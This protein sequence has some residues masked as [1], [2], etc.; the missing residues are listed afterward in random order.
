MFS[1]SSATLSEEDSLTVRKA[2]LTL[3]PQW[4][5]IGLALGIPIFKLNE[6]TG[7]DRDKM[8][9]MLLDWLNHSFSTPTWRALVTALREPIVAHGIPVADEIEAE[10]GGGQSPYTTGVELGEK[11]TCTSMG[12]GWIMTQHP[13]QLCL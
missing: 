5:N 7:T 3:R 12:T 13:C 2:L 6:Y 9:M 1:S 11:C 8:D 10:Y 4:R